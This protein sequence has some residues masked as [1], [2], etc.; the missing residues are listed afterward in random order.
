MLLFLLKGD[1]CRPLNINM[2]QNG[3]SQGIIYN[4]RPGI[5][6]HHLDNVQVPQNFA[7]VEQVLFKSFTCLLKLLSFDGTKKGK[8]L[9]QLW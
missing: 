9:Q 1:G 7:M 2:I 5:K 3:R 8:Y 4:S 6:V